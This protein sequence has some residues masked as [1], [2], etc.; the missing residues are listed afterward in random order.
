M[1]SCLRLGVQWLL[2]LLL[3]AGWMAGFAQ[4]QTPDAQD[5]AAFLATIGELREAT[6]A[7]KQAIVERLSQGGH[8]NVRAVLTAFLE[9]RLYYRDADQMV[10]QP[11]VT[12]LCIDTSFPWMTARASTL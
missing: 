10:A 12:A 5:D 8:R 3:Y 11:E 2:L 4:A 9:D 1:K 6:F 7:D